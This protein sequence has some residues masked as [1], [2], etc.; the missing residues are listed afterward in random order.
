MISTILNIVMTSFLSTKCGFSLIFFSMNCIITP[1]K[2]VCSL[3]RPVTGGAGPIRAGVP[4]TL[5]FESKQFGHIYYRLF[6]C[7]IS[8]CS[9]VL[10]I[11]EWSFLKLVG[12]L[13]VRRPI[14]RRSTLQCWP[15]VRRRTVVRTWSSLSRPKRWT[16]WRALR[17]GSWKIT[18]RYVIL[19]ISSRLIFMCDIWF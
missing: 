5:F 7:C 19:K 15:W 1:G 13:I 9:P 14:V 6:C 12:V 16:C 8:R 4:A 10:A 17:R 18:R 3:I 2:L 11:I